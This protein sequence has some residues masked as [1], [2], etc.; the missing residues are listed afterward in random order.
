M[1]LV[2]DN[3]DSF[4]FNVARYFEEL[5]ARTVVRR[6]DALSAEDVAASGA[7]AL[8]L[9]P[10]PCT[11][12]EAGISLEL[13]ARFSGKLP[14]LGICLGHQC[15]GE[16]FGGR[17]VRARTPMHGRSSAIHH[18]GSGLFHGLP[19][20]V[21]A[22]RYHSLIVELPEDTPLSVTARSPDGEVMAVE[23][24]AHPTYG[25]QFHP[26][27]VLTPRGPDIIRAFLDRVA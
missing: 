3:Y 11:P 16:A 21:E 20:P 7:K 14:I 26:E 4:V 22:G 6:N 27:S 5:G 13:V 9:S 18:D 15:V 2:L 19:S 24:R 17:T 10:G 8:V 25:I 1:I 23:H 12:R